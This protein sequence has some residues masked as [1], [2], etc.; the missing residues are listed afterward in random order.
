V[1]NST[2]TAPVEHASLLQIDPR[3]FQARLDR[4]PFLVRHRPEHN[5]LLQIR[6][7]KQVSLFDGED[8]EL[9]TERELEKFY[10]RGHRNLVSPTRTSRR[11][12]SSRSRPATGS[13]SP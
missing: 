10:A 6:G 11:P 8:R 3:R 9:V 5:F 1:S 4:Q 13:T 12:R 7:Q 2:A